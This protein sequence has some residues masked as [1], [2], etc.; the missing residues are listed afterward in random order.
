MGVGKPLTPNFST[1]NQFNTTYKINL[2]LSGWDQTT[3]HVV[4]PVI[5]RINILGSNDSGEQQQN[6]QGNATLAIN[7]S[8]IQAT[9]L[10]TGSSVNAIYGPGLFKIPVNAQFLSL[11]GSP[12][13]TPTNVYRI[14]IFN[15][16]TS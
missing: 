9:D 11:Q 6:T 4:G 7:F 15:S 14:R 3:V 13:A 1:T 8:P 10:S 12:A 16:K 5:G 2:D